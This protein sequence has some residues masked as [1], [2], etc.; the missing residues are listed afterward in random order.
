MNDLDDTDPR[1]PEVA[2]ENAD[3]RRA[4]DKHDS[5]SSDSESSVQP[6]DQPDT[7][8]DD[9]PAVSHVIRPDDQIAI[10]PDGQP[11]IQSDGQHIPQPVVQPP[12][13]T[14]VKPPVQQIVSPN[15]GVPF[16]NNY[17]L[18]VTYG[19]TPYGNYGYYPQVGNVGNGMV[20][21]V[22]GQVQYIAYP[23][24]VYCPVAPI[25]AFY[26]TPPPQPTT[27]AVQDDVI[28]KLLNT[29]DKTLG[30]QSSCRLIQK[31]LEEESEARRNALVSK[32]F[33]KMVN[34][35][36]EY[37]NLPFGNYLCQKCF[38]LLNEKQL[39][40]VIHR[41]K[42][43]AVSISNNLHGTRSIQK[44]IESSAKH[45]ELRVALS[46]VMSGHVTA[47]VMVNVE[48]E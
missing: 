14:A 19:A 7:P 21:G 8:S 39:S 12:I 2:N 23:A 15:P 29:I 41:I 20:P 28:D 32:L 24:Y 4:D 44:L 5:D 10:Q 33:G 43:S 6:D 13:R 31:K 11:A 34:K 1:V 16:V 48:N 42:P 46:E 37:M 35:I 22:P 18:P 38:E 30:D 9:K 25:T 40:E 36:A 27:V 47:L 26:V 3:E 45:A 17:G